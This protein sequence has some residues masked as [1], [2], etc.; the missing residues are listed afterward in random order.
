MARR[1]VY[2]AL[3]L[4]TAAFVSMPQA[5][6][7]EELSS[8]A[9]VPRGRLVRARARALSGRLGVR[10]G[11]RALRARADVRAGARLLRA[12]AL[13]FS[14]RAQALRSVGDDGGDGDVIVID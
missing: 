1:R 13:E 5:G 6:L 11:A 4:A 3:A 12:D 14:A 8:G 7:G 2:A 9:R 10:A